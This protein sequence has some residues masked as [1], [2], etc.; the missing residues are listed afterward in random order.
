MDQARE[1]SR[2]VGLTPKNKVRRKLGPFGGPA[3]SETVVTANVF[4]TE[5]QFTET[6]FPFTR[7]V[8]VAN[9]DPQ[10]FT[11]MTPPRTALGAGQNSLNTNG[12]WV[13]YAATTS[14]LL[15]P[16]HRNFACMK[17]DH[18]GWNCCNP[19]QWNAN[20]TQFAYVKTSPVVL[21]ITLPDPPISKA[22]P[23]TVFRPPVFRAAADLLAYQTENFGGAPSDGVPM[24]N[25]TRPTGAWQYIII[26]AQKGASIRLD[27]V[28]G[29]VE[30]QKLLQ[31]GYKPQTCRGKT[32]KC[33]CQPKGADAAEQGSINRKLQA[34]AGPP[35]GVI[36][37]FNAGNPMTGPGLYTSVHKTQETD[38][39][40]Q[41]CSAPVGGFLDTFG[42]AGLQAADFIS[43]GFDVLAFGSA[44]VFQ[45]LQ[46]APP[47][48]DGTVTVM[49][50]LLPLTLTVHSKTTFR[51]LKT[52]SQDLGQ[53]ATLPIVG[54]V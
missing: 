50:Q 15:D 3:Q 18:P 39:S 13:G 25:E 51:Q 33:V 34:L 19:R 2:R 44:I 4:Q 23:V 20:I 36:P 49:R 16:Y 17:I 53:V 48:L 27:Q 52:A 1:A 30:W 41:Y 40:V 45:F 5:L 28:C 42:G 43:Q 8:D 35:P 14:T 29:Y 21:E 10:P 6:S 38:W 31:I 47:C 54:G 12:V 22:L 9:M 32:Y 7:L 24:W 37:P 46:Y 11:T 26:P